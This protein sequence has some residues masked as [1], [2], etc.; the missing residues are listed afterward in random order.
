MDTFGIK[1]DSY[2]NGPSKLVGGNIQQSFSL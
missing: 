1:T 2:T